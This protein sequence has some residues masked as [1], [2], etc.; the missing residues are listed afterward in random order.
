MIATAPRGPGQVRQTSLA[1]NS[2]GADA[3]RASTVRTTGRRPGN[4]AARPPNRAVGTTTIPA[5]APRSS[6]DAAVVRRHRRPPR[7]RLASA[8]PSSNPITVQ[9]PTM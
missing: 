9:A 8:A 2:A 3:A 7:R 5:P 6:D 1:M 4:P